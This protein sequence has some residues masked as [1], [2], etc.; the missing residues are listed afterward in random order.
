MRIR[1]ISVFHRTAPLTRPY[2]LSGG[3]LRFEELDCTFV[4]VEADNGLVGW[5]EGTPWGHTYLPAHGGGIRAAAELLAPALLDRDPRQPDRINRLMDLTLPGHLYAK[6]PF[7]IACWDL[8]GQSVGLPIVDLLGGR[9]EEPTP[10]AS[11]I[12]TDTPDGMLAEINLYRDMGYYVHSVK[13][14][15]SD[16]DLDIARIRHLKANERPGEFIF[17][18][19]N[20]AWTPAEAITVM[21]G[22][23]DLPVTFEQPC[24]TLD[25]CAQVRALT[26]QPISIDERLET[27]GD[28]L[29]IT[30]GH[31]GEVVNIKINRVG[32]LTKARR[33]R[34][35]G[36]AGGFK[37]LVMESGGTVVADTQTQH[38]AQSIPR[39][40]R[41]GTWLCQ[42]MLSVDS[43]PGRGAR[44]NGKGESVAPDLPGLGV[45]PDED[46]LGDPVAVYG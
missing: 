26:R 23:A 44:N 15:G 34:D 22:V 28:M 13:V 30:A 38:L 40:L 18:D 6:S 10:I 43:A 8:F 3:R 21:N 39:D 4:K 37:F 9:H 19:V 29:R 12:S 17:Y 2:K 5:G 11:S 42:E 41:L 36:L 1:R 7:D 27:E 45:A 31:I 20:R 46:F 16:T 33:I 14:G 35:I 25:Q 32:G 24:E